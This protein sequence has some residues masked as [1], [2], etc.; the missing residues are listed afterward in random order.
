LLA[1]VASGCAAPVNPQVQQAV[2]ASDSQSPPV[3]KR[4]TA[5]VIADFPTVIGKLENLSPGSDA[6][7]V[8]IGAGLTA[9]DGQGMLMPVLAESVPSLE[10]GLWQVFPDGRM[11]TTWRLRP[12]LRWHDGAPFTADDV[13]FTGKLARDPELPM[14]RHPGIPLVE[15]IEAVDPATVRVR[16]KQPYITADSLFAPS[17][18]ISLVTIPLP[19]HIL[20]APY[21]EGG[22]GILV[23]PY[24]S[25]GFVGMGP[26]RLREWLP[27]ALS[28]WRPTRGTRSGDRSS[29][30]SKF[31]SSP[32]TTRLSR[33][34]SPAWS[35]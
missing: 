28:C 22:R 14:F 2:G 30:K 19:Q 7:E 34:S 4:V 16:W 3:R 33:A 26:F 10:N 1:V 25:E 5:G 18:G 23:N 31:A 21:L 27:A 15:S 6:V 12:G 35:T 9:P 20:E 17:P 11:E 32:M 29:T 8:M 24:W 13:V